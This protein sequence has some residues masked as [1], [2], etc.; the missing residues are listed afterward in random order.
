MAR[1]KARGRGRPPADDRMVQIAIRL[2]SVV[3]DYVDEQLQGRLDGKDRSSFIR[4]LL[5][6]AIEARQRSGRAR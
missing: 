5:A 4:E 2:P 1:Q 6:E 3:L